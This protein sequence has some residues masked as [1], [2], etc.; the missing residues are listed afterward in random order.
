MLVEFYMYDVY[1][2]YG[3]GSPEYQELL[4]QKAEADSEFHHIIY[5]PRENPV[6]CSPRTATGGAKGRYVCCLCS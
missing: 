2:Q 4:Q 5:T 6:Y 1:L 3:H